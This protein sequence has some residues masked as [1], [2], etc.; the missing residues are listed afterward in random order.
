VSA[1]Y[2]PRE[3]REAKVRRLAA[4]KVMTAEERERLLAQERSEAAQ[5]EEFLVSLFTPDRADND[6]DAL[7]SIWRVALV[8][9]EVGETLPSRVEEQRADATLRTLFPTVG[10]FDVVYRVRFPRPALSLEGRPSFILRIAGARGRIDLAF[11]Q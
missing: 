4:W 7:R 3:V 1:V 11:A 6:L 2:L 8:V 9:P 10:E 5:Y